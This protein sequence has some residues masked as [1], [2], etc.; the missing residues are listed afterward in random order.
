[1]EYLE[2]LPESLKQR[3]Y[4]AGEEAAWGKQDA[5]NVIEYFETKGVVVDGIEVWLPTEPGPTIPTPFIYTWTA[6]E[7]ATHQT[8]GQYVAECNESAKRYIDTFQWDQED[9]VH[10]RLDPYFNLL[11]DSKPGG[12]EGGT[13]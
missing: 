12:A 6:E 3:A 11:L 4:C 10:K 8:W 7:Q 13:P 9:T 2:L 5:K 1:M